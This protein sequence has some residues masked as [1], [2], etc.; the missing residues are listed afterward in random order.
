MIFVGDMF[1][2][3]PVVKHGAE[4][5]LLR[6][7]YRTN[8]Y[9]FYKSNAVKRIR[10][11]KIEFQKVYRQEDIK[12]LHILEN[13]RL[14]RVTPENI[15]HLNEH[16]H[17]PSNEDGAVITL[18]STPLASKTFCKASELITVAIIPI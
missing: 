4:R 10:L 12:F 5:D 17:T 13:V 14:N 11:V 8:D 2:L 15:M 7:F 3:P 18:V 16:V 9:F 1:Q 6:D